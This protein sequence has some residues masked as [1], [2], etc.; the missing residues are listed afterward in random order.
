MRTFTTVISGEDNLCFTDYM[1]V[2]TFNFNKF[3]PYEFGLKKVFL[4]VSTVSV[5]EPQAYG[6]SLLSS[7]SSTNSY[8]T[9]LLYK[10][11]I[12]SC[13]RVTK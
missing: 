6:P 5:G 8:T 9:V 11:A 7:T 13:L 3:F 10:I 4:V 2:I 12:S 1:P